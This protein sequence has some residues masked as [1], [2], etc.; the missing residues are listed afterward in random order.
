MKASAFHTPSATTSQ[1]S[2]LVLALV[3][4]AGSAQAQNLLGNPGFDSPPLRG[5]V[6]VLNDF[7]GQQNTWGA[8]QGTL[9]SGTSF[10]YVTALGTSMLS[11]TDEGGTATQTAQVVGAGSKLD[12]LPEQN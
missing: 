12:F 3:G 4:A 6:T 5:F 11:M 10:D 8:E 1:I 9:V 7:A 2:A